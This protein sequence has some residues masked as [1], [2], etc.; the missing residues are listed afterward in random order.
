MRTRAW[1]LALAL[2]LLA[3]PASANAAPKRHYY[4][5]LGDSYA[6]GYQPNGDYKHGFTDYLYKSLH[7]RD[8]HLKLINL[9]CG[10]ATTESMI[11]GNKPCS[12]QAKLPY[13]N[14]SKK[15]SQLSYA[16]KWL[17][18]HRK[19]VRFV[20]IAIGG[21]DVA[22]CTK[23]GDL[24]AIVACVA[25]GIDKIKKNLPVIAK[26]VR[27]A[28]GKKTIVVGTTY[29]D[30]VLGDWV[31][32]ED[33]QNLA[34]ASVPIF[35][36]QINP[37]MKAAYMKQHIRFVDATADFGGYTP[38]DQTTT[39]E[40]FGEIPVAVAQICQYGWFCE[41][42]DIHLRSPGYKLLAGFILDTIR[43]KPYSVPTG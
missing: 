17:R 42:Q 4:V 24:N 8:K 27:T 12:P 11:K 23:A 33:G 37:A 31:Q 5:S 38:L 35:H 13:K 28:A 36:D 6:F 2:L 1:P 19:Q 14:K 21:N 3:L 41:R 15:T 22:S 16:K 26:G 40:P 29:P 10:G 9:G 34:K 30:V 7:K 43:G 25:T 32:G 39:F 20:T 18:A